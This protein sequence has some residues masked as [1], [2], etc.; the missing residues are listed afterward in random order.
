MTQPPE[1]AHYSD[2]G[3][4]WWDGAAWQAVP[5][6]HG[7]AGG[8]AA[9]GHQPGAHEPGGHDPRGHDGS[10]H[11]GVNQAGVFAFL[12]PTLT[13]T[14]K[15]SGGEPLAHKELN[16]LFKAR[17]VGGAPARARVTLTYAGGTQTEI[18]QLETDIAAGEDLPEGLGFSFDIKAEAGMQ[19]FS[20]V[21][22]P[23]M[24]GHDVA[25]ATVEVRTS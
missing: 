7:A 15:A 9:A 24:P 6:G 19:A 11:G 23:G 10:A 8:H 1:G 5:P 14:D 4:Y 21:I 18:L 12:E 22:E 2:D 25:E 13:V 3:Y 17:N 16:V 20:A